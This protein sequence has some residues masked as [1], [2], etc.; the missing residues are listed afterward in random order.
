MVLVRSP[1]GW[2]NL[3]QEQ[4]E[5]SAPALFLAGKKLSFP[6][7]GLKA[8]ETVRAVDTILIGEHNSALADLVPFYSS[9]DMSVGHARQ[10]EKIGNQF[11]GQ[12]SKQWDVPTNRSLSGS[13]WIGILEQRV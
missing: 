6:L 11:R 5:P 10:L 9:A 7:F 13:F 8:G 1:A 3:E 12:W 2:E 4:R